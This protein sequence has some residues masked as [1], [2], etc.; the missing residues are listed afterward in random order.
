MKNDIP[1]KCGHAW[2]EHSEGLKPIGHQGYPTGCN[3]K[4]HIG[5][6]CYEYVPDNLTFIEQEAKRR[7]LI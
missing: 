5:D 4:I 6:F 1:C 7:G 3:A 2:E